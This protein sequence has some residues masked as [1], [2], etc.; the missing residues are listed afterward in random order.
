MAV[1]DQTTRTQH[2]FEPY[3]FSDAVPGVEIVL[4]T[5][6][7]DARVLLDRRTLKLIGSLH[8]R[9]WSRRKDLL[10]G[11]AQS[12]CSVAP[13]Y[14]TVESAEESSV[15][16]I[17]LAGPLAQTWDGRLCLHRELGEMVEADPTPEVERR[18]A[19]RGW[20]ETE[21]GVLVDGRSVPGCVFDLALALQSGADS[22]RRHDQPFVVSIPAAT[23]AEE[24]RLWSDLSNLA[25]DRTGIDRGT[26]EIRSD[27][28]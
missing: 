17:D 19:I 8:R 13:R 11:R 6:E 28:S 26:V 18:I 16:V 15:R 24:E 20:G 9:F 22:F 3:P 14:P 27:R 12:G 7:A 25:H 4:P 5:D 1:T 10:F 23:C 21:P 2:E